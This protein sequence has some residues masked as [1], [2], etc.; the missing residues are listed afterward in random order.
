MYGVSFNNPNFYYILNKISSFCVFVNFIVQIYWKVLILPNFLL[1]TFDDCFYKKKLLFDFYLF[2][3]NTCIEYDGEFHY[4][5]LG[6]NDLESQ[7]I[8]DNIKNEYCSKKNIH[9]LRIPYFNR[10]MIKD[11]I[12]NF[13]NV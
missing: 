9:L 6:F 5:D 8:K 4:K 10:E 12:N 3:Y 11:I 2:D 1:F 7:K 13:L